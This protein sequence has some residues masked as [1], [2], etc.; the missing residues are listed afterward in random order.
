MTDAPIHLDR[1]DH[2]AELVL[3]RPQRRNALNAAMWTALPDLLDEAAGDDTIKALVVR[4]A[5][6]SFTAGADI[7]E[8][9]TVYATA[10]AAQTYTNAIA[11]GLDALAHFPKPTLAV[12]RGACIGGGCGLALS[13]D[14]RFTASD[15]RFGITPAKLGLA[16]TLNDTKRLIDAVGVSTAKDLLYSARLIDATE[17]LA[18]GLVNRCFEPDELDAE[19][20]AYLEMMLSRSTGSARAIKRVIHLIRQGV[21]GD[22]DETRQLFLDAFQSDDFREGYNAFL[23]K[24]TPDFTGQG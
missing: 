6:G 18:M 21:D 24:R 15:G 22:T 17:A 19:V 13:C 16:Y 20:G 2:H 3:N 12:I 14:L 4:G 1:H 10:E 5:G 11:R 7:S 9:D 23:G 8:F